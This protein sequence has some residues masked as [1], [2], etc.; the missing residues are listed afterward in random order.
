MLSTG[1]TVIRLQGVVFLAALLTSLPSLVGAAADVLYLYGSAPPAGASYQLRLNDTGPTGLSQFKS[2]VQEL[3]LS[4]EERLDTTFTLS[5]AAL[6]DY[7]VLIFGSNNRSF[8]AAG[9]AALRAFVAQS[10]GALV[11]SAG[12]FWSV[13]GVIASE[14]VNGRKIRVLLGRRGAFPA[15]ARLYA[16]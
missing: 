16:D 12:E 10:G 5:E 15:N 9:M 11:F 8:T 3:G 4:I 1:R 2:A 7:S 13:T 6:K 14:M